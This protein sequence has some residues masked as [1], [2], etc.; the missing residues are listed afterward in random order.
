MKEAQTEVEQKVSTCLNEIKSPLVELTRKY[1]RLRLKRNMG[2]QRKDRPTTNL[3][4]Q[5]R[6]IGARGT[7]CVD[8][9]QLRT[10]FLVHVILAMGR[11]HDNQIEI[12]GIEPMRE[13]Q[14]AIIKMDRSTRHDNSVVSKP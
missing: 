6:Q 11:L 1:L 12:T 13:E 3:M 9:N 10:P 14:R 2:I 8:V 7:G 4:T 5:C